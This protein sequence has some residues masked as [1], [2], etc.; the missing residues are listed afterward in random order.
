MT[1]G[2]EMEY[3]VRACLFEYVLDARLIANIG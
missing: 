1:F 3:R 2:R